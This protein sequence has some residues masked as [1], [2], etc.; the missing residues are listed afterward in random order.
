MEHGHTDYSSII[1]IIII[2]LIVLF[3]ISFMLFIRR[4]LI[5]SSLKNKQS[6]DIK[7]KLDKIISLL[8]KERTDK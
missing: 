7:N 5:N 8:E 1:S 2:I 3:V 6:E 4:L